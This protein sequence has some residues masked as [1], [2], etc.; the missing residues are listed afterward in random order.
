MWPLRIKNDFGLI[1]S[2]PRR[3]ARS[4][5]FG[6][7]SPFAFGF[8]RDVIGCRYAYYRYP[9]IAR[10]ARGTSI[11]E[12]VLRL[13]FRIAC[14]FD[15]R[16]MAV[17]AP[18]GTAAVIE[19]V[20]KLTRTD[21]TVTVNDFTMPSAP[22]IVVTCGDISPEAMSFLRRCIKAHGTVIMTGVPDTR[23]S[24]TLLMEDSVHGMTFADGSTAIAVGL[25]HLP[26]QHY[27][28]RI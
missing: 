22:D 18:D 19:D 28:I 6:V 26:R 23:Q 27:E 15:C 12:R 2:A 8:I 9:D 7:H 14:R 4:Q 25:S 17:A 1:L 11:Q 5:G 10:I 21:A 13:I 16:H 24:I 3:L 20:L